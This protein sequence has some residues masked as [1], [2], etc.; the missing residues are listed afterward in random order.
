MHLLRVYAG[1][2]RLTAQH[3]SLSLQSLLRDE[4]FHKIKQI[5]GI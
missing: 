4:L 5:A 1:M 3:S 2:L